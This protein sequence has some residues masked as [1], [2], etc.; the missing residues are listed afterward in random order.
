MVY[1][2]LSYQL[3][4]KFFLHHVHYLNDVIAALTLEEWVMLMVQ[5]NELNKIK[6]APIRLNNNGGI[7]VHFKAKEKLY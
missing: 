2:T 4:V 7:T 1:Q 5:M 3:I 6:K